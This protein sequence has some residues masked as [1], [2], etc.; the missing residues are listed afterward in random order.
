MGEPHSP[1]ALSAE[2]TFDPTL[3]ALITLA[4]GKTAIVSASTRAL[5][6]ALGYPPVPHL[7]D[8]G[9][10]HRYLR[11]HSL[12]PNGCKTKHTLT[13]LLYAVIAVHS[14]KS[15]RDRHPAKGFV[16]STAN[17][18]PLDLRDHNLVAKPAEGAGQTYHA[19]WDVRKRWELLDRGLDPNTVY[20]DRRRAARMVAHA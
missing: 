19:I 7:N 18:D 1:T 14:E 8:N 6:L 20:A 5:Y 12:L 4:D 9:K 11:I 3:D 16:V 10:G 15:G 13:R 17:G 2:T